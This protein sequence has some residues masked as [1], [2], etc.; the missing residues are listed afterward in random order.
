MRP[1]H[2]QARRVARICGIKRN[3]ILRQLKIEE[4]GAQGVDDPTL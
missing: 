2:Q 1:H 3:P 4:I